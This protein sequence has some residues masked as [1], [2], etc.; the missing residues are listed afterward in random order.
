MGLEKYISKQVQ[1]NRPD[2]MIYNLLSDF[3]NFT[4]MLAGKVDGWEVD[5][6]SCS[7]TVKGIA[8]NIRFVEKIP[9]STVKIGGD[10]GSPFEFFFWIQL[11]KVGE[12]D[13]RMRLTLHA[14]L[15]MMMKMMLGKKL[16]EGIDQIAE[17]IATA[18]NMTPEEAQHMADQHGW[19][20]PGGMEEGRMPEELE[21]SPFDGMDWPMPDPDKP[22]S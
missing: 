22:V 20:M 13:T 5:G 3:N 8:L 1:I 12:Y 7:F 2:W 16:Q 4:P 18:F 19:Q 9:Y 21:S 6:D 17:Q 14:N 10:E 15:N 11:V